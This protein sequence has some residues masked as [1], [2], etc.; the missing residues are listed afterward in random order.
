MKPTRILIILLVFTLLLAACG[1]GSKEATPVA[2]TPPSTQTA[3]AL[4]IV[5]ATYGRGL[6]DEMGAT[7]TGSRFE[8][9][10]NIYLSVKLEGNPKEGVVSAD[11][12]HGDERI[13]DA[14]V[15]LAQSR[16]DQGVLFVVGGNTQ[17][18]FSLTH[19][20][21]FPISD[22]YYTDV[23]LDGEKAASYPFEIVRPAAALAPQIRDVA[24]AARGHRYLRPHRPG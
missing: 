7:E 24:L 14:S 10:Q 8:P 3:S 15:D 17:V 16:E 2:G 19:D 9:D 23:Y 20:D 5:D 12:Y 21:P 1:G 13:A 18:G 22:Q 6:D 4:Q 11:F